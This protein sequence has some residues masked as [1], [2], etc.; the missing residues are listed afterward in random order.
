MRNIFHAFVFVLVLFAFFGCENNPDIIKPGEL[1]LIGTDSPVSWNTDTLRIRGKFLGEKNDSAFLVINDTIVFK[2]YDCLNWNN[3]FIDFIVPDIFG[4]ST[5]KIVSY[6]KE[7]NTLNI[8]FKHYP[9]FLTVEISGASFPMGSNSGFDD[10]L[11]V[12]TVTLNHKYIVSA[13]EISTR[14][15]N[16]VSKEKN[17]SSN[18][19]FPVT[20]LTW[21][22]AID[23]CNEMSVLDGLE[24]AYR[25]DT[26]GNITWDTLSKGWRLPTEAEWEFLAKAGKSAELTS[27]EFAERAWT[28]GNSGMNYAKCGV[29]IANDFGLYDMNGNAWE[30]CWDY[31]DQNYYSQKINLN[32]LGPQSGSRRVMRGG[33]AREGLLFARNANRNIPDGLNKAGIR[34]IRNI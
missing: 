11:P 23:F 33:S 30:W 18:G 24:P 2:S 16:S 19:D 21:E 20:D 34:I 3:S 25:T 13:H 27:I 10:E 4:Q 12:R 1:E 28:S 22:Q 7:S 14:I 31:F 9:P 26:H 6:R 29:K 15:F 5:I 32:P 17:Y 8:E